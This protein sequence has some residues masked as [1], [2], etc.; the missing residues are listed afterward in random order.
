M[1]KKK[2]VE[3]VAVDEQIE[4]LVEALEP[5]NINDYND[6]PDRCYD[7]DVVEVTAYSDAVDE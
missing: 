4:E 2:I 6:D 7:L 5:I 1:A 3:E